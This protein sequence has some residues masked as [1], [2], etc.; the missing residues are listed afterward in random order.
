MNS[1]GIDYSNYNFEDF[2]SIISV[3]QKV[4]FDKTNVSDEFWFKD[5]LIFAHNEQEYEQGLNPLTLQ[6]KDGS[7][8]FYNFEK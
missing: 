8:S 2:D 5:G 3:L 6:W 4:E 1:K 7:N